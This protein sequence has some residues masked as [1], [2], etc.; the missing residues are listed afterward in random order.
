MAGKPIGVGIVGIGRAG[1]GMHRKELAG[2]EEKFK[3]VAACD[4]IKE[5]CD[6]MA[7]AYGCATYRRIEDM[8]RDPNVELVDIATPSPLHV[9]HALLALKA[10]K[11]VFLEKPIAL[12]YRDAR[13][14]VN[15][16]K[17]KPGNLFIRHNRRFEPGFQH[18]KEIIESGIL[19]D[20]YEIKLRRHNYQRRD[21][22]QTIIDCGGGQLLNWG[23]HVV[24]H[25]LR[26]LGGKV[27]SM[28]SDLRRIA[29][30]G[31]AEDHVHIILKGGVKK[32]LV[33][34]LE[35]SGGV[36]KS[37]PTYIVFGTRG[38]LTSSGSSISLCY[39]DPK[40]KL[41]RRRASRKTPEVGSG[42][43]ADE[44]LQWI[45]EDI[46]VNPSTKCKCEDIWDHLYAAIRQNKPFPVKLEEALQ[47]MEILS[48]ARKGTPFEQV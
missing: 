13:K 10:G 17:S 39:L 15:A 9:P 48:M 43:G 8:L 1:N 22:W 19:G 45:K 42:F 26:F 29:A 27:D 41:V 20:V 23:P 24:D 4:V 6:T 2:R 25:A 47:V 16:V 38:S 14:L 3:I 37:E 28:W 35:I 34:D 36:A 5:R 7:E 12:S 40:Q 33:V 18:V 21:D 31:D 11:K 46:S 32:S 44:T 30:M